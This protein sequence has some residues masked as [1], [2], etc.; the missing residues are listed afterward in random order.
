MICSYTLLP[1]APVCQNVGN[2]VE[3]AGVAYDEAWAMGHVCA[4]DATDDVFGLQDG[5]GGAPLAQHVGG[6]EPGRAGT[7]HDDRPDVCGVGVLGGGGGVRRGQ[8]SV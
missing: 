6:R 8:G 7:D 2:R 3:E 5:G 4:G 1:C